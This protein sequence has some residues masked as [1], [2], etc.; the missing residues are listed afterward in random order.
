VKMN[1]SLLSEF[2][3]EMAATR[4]FLEL[5]PNEK[6]GW[7]PHEKSMTIGQLAWHLSD[8]P[9]WCRYTFKLDTLR[10]SPDDYQKKVAE[11]QGKGAKEILAQFEGDL[12]DAR[13]QLAAADDAALAQQWK[14]IFGEQTIV[15]MPRRE[16]LRKW[17]M[18]H[19]IH[20]RAQL[21]V[22]LRLNGIAIPGVYG[23][24]ADETPS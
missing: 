5:V 2:D 11:R 18:N 1:E 7:K 16:V 14:M 15:D 4:K 6:L 17:V 20:H 8:M 22:F 9:S 12:N 21:G 10:L 3:E 19:L 24:S 13:A 23:P